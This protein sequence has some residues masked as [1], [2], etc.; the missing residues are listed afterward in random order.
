MKKI[1][2]IGII[3]SL[4]GC[5]KKS[6]VEGFNGLEWG[7]SLFTVRLEQR[8]E[9]G[10]SAPELEHLEP[11][12][13][14]TLSYNIDKESGILLEGELISGVQ[15]GFRCFAMGVDC[16]LV[17]GTFFLDDES[18]NLFAYIEERI[19]DSYSFKAVEEDYGSEQILSKTFIFEDGSGI[20]LNR[21]RL[22]KNSSTYLTFITYLSHAYEKIEPKKEIEI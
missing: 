11:L 9:E 21:T 15:Y 20:Y 14:Y 22:T 8:L 13:E 4:Y 16:E 18:P 7:A 19:R 10:Q 12:G 2:L 6:R 17:S 3:L 1:L 5:G